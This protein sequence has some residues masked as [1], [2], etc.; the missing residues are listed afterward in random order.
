MNRREG[1]RDRWRATVL[2]SPHITDSVRV[3]LLIL[4]D[5]MTEK[6]YVS[7]PR[8]AI[9]DAIGRTP[10]RVTERLEKARDAGLLDVVRSGRPGRTAEYVAVIPSPLGADGRT[11][12]GADC[13][14]HSWRTGAPSETGIS[15]PAWCGRGSN[16]Y[17]R[18]V[19]ETRQSN[20]HQRYAGAERT[21]QDKQERSEGRAAHTLRLAAFSPWHQLAYA[22]LTTVSA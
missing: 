14:T 22:P 6:G 4:A 17:A 2:R 11:T 9:A 10:R 8:T 1:L 18:V 20:G 21:H 13:S 7:I 3:V 16:Q 19:N 15:T 12:H 5:H